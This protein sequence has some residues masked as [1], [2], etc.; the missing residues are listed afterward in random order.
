MLPEDYSNYS[1]LTE[2]LEE[3]KREAG[4]IQVRMSANL[5]RIR[6]TETYM[7]GLRASESEDFKVFSP[8]KA[9]VLHREELQEA[10]ERKSGYE[11]EN[12]ELAEKRELL[13][14]RIGR[15][16]ELVDHLEKETW[17]QTKEMGELSGKMRKSLQELADKLD[18]S[19]AYVERNPVQARQNLAIIGKCLRELAEGM[20]DPVWGGGQ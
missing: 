6:E 8:R 12:G 13:N 5:R 9:E 17:H 11:R 19:S 16:Q 15:L 7:D 3:L 18:E 20:K 14:G 4:E 2:L 10:Q 1:I